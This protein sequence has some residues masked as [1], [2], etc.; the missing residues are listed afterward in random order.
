MKNQYFGDR[1]DFFKFE[2]LLD[3]ATCHQRRRL[4]VVPMLTPNDST[5]E[6]NV[7]TYECG[8][9]RRG[10][11]DSLRHAVALGERDIRVL[12]DVLP[13]CGTE[14]LSYRDSE[15]FDNESRQA[16]FD[17]VPTDSLAGSVVFLGPDIGL[18]T[19]TTSYMRSNG[20]DKYLLYS[21]LSQIAARA[22][23]DSI[24]VVYQHLQRNASLRAADLD[25]RRRDVETAL[26]TSFV[27][28]VQWADLAFLVAVRDNEV[29]GR[30]A[31]TLQHHAQRHDGLF[32]GGVESTD[33]LREERPVPER[34]KHGM[35]GRFCSLCAPKLR[36]MPHQ[37]SAKGHTSTP[38]TYELQDVV[39]F[40]NNEQ[41][42]A[43]YGA[44]AEVVGGIARGIGAR[45]TALYSRSSEASWVVSAESGLPTG[46]NLNERHPAL[47]TK[48]EVIASGRELEERMA[49]RKRTR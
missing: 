21:D 28:A 17:G 47:L 41:V 48:R 7:T 23:N 35:D 30:V 20:S 1:R 24:F 45:L 49:G 6:G 8:A 12:R 31:K 14:I 11:F 27:Y 37:T 16:Y 32:L 42:R 13:R 44:V 4:L 15:Y 19:G 18:E 46:Y 9:R 34:C 33:A 29:A 43:T 40:L 25:R 38:G 10:L 3:L 26:R 39:R 2:L 5:G 22:S 36:A